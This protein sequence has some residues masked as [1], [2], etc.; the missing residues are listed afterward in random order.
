MKS[1]NH[2][3]RF[4]HHLKLKNFDIFGATLDPS[5]HLPNVNYPSL[6]RCSIEAVWALR[7]LPQ[8][9]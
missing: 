2:L 9:W 1:Q 6:E 3:L 8:I 5:T 4:L 7:S